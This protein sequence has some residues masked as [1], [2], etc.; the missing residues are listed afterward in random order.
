MTFQYN[1]KFY[2]L[3]KSKTT[4]HVCIV[5]TKNINHLSNFTSPNDFDTKLCRIILLQK[6]PFSLAKLTRNNNRKLENKNFH[7]TI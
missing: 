2:S 5:Y 6:I 4:I 7:S 1:F 3:L